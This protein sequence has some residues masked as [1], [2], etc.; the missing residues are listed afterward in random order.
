MEDLKDPQLYAAAVDKL[1]GL[2]QRITDERLNIERKCS[3]LE[4][5]PW[6]PQLRD[7]VRRKTFFQIWVSEFKLK[8]DLSH[9]HRK[10]WDVLEEK[11]PT[12][13]AEAESLL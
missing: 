2:Q 3:K 5:N 9:Q 10:V 1:E 8:K 13:L 12:N 7:A 6:S 4:N 11:V